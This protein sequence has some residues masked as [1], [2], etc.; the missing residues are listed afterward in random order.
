M[1]SLLNMICFIEYTGIH[2]SFFRCMSYFFYYFYFFILFYFL[3]FFFL[4]GGGGGG[5]G[6]GEGQLVGMSKAVHTN[7]DVR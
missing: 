2:Y 1:S 7:S 6:G 3:F 5:G 4:G